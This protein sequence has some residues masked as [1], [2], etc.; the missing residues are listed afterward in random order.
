MKSVFKKLFKTVAFLAILLVALY[1]IC[2]VFSFKYE[3]GVTPMD[4]MY[5]LPEDTVDVVLLGSSHM[6]VNVDPSILWEEEGVAAYNCWGSMQQVWNTY[7]YLNECLKY[8]N[9]K[10][11]VMDVYGAT[12]AYDYGTYDNAVKNTIGMRM[13]MDKVEAI[14]TS[15]EESDYFVYL[16]LGLPTYHYRYTELT[17]DD[18]T[19]FFWDKATGIQTVNTAGEVVQPIT[20]TDWGVGDETLPLNAKQQEYLIKII[21]LCREKDVPLLLIAAPYY[22][23]ATE[24]KRFNEIGVVAEKYG[25]PYLNYCTDCEAIGLDSSED[26]RDLCHLMSSGIRKYSVFLGNYIKEHYDVPDRRT[27]E[28]HIWNRQGEEDESLIYQLDTKFYGGGQEYVDTGVQLCVNPYSSYTLFAE[29]D[30]R[31]ES[32]NKVWFSCYSEEDNAQRGILFRK[33]G[34]NLYLVIS[35]TETIEIPD[36]TDITRIAIVK[37]GLEYSLYVNGAYYKN[38]IVNLPDSYDGTLLLGCQVDASGKRFRFSKTEILDLQIY[39]GTLDSATVTSWTG[40]DLPEPPQRQAQAA[41]SDAA[42]SLNEQFIGDGYSSY[43]DTGLALYENTEASWT[44]LTQF[45]EGCDKGAGVYFS[46]YAE[47][48]TDYRGVMARRVGEGQINLLYGN[49]SVVYEV[50][51]GSD[52]SM[53]IVKD[54]IAYTVYLNGEKIVDEDACDTNAWTG[55]LLIGCQESMEQEK[56]RFSGVAIYN[57]EVYDGVMNEDDI[58]AWNPEHRPEP[59]PKEASPVDYTLPAPFLGDGSSNYVD[60]GAQLYDVA[61]KSWSLEITFQKSGIGH[62]LTCFAENPA[63]YR[64]LIVTVA[65]D[66]TLNLTLGQSAM[67]VEMGPRP[68]HT[69]KIVKQG[70]DYTVYLDGE[71][72]GQVTSEA[73]TYDGTLLVGCAVDGDGNLFRFSTAKI[74]SLTVT[75]KIQ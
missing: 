18:F 13:S 73:P 23:D 34:N 63:S 74:L 49:R 47:D 5:D 29:I 32:D 19:N 11:V 51:A 45:R 26:Y 43:L 42:F 38:A 25:V 37:E 75:D 31:C 64:G 4:H 17:E 41:H 24:V 28:N 12:F 35:A 33:S 65:D 1:L 61:D 68:E 54:G 44:L 15:V 48:I 72:A 40:R 59:T 36:Y 69:L 9:P 52:V 27:D 20:I 57:F 71:L 14:Q 2:C 62:L 22:L 53:A 16:L 50:P 21:E 46:C 70:S 60:T 3:D 39:S 55:N 66:T 67:E 7:Y 8:Q 58:L 56:M 6:G 10:L 30:T